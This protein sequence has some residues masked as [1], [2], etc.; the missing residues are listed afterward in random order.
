MRSKGCVINVDSTPPVNPATRCS[1]RNPLKN[2]PL[3]GEADDLCIVY[4]CVCYIL[5]TYPETAIRGT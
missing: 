4:D 2:V 1:Y 3:E 5:L